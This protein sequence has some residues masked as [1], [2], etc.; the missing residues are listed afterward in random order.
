MSD[1]LDTLEDAKLSEVF[2]VEVA[3]GPRCSKCGHFHDELNNVISEVGFA[4]DANA[5]LPWL[6][7]HANPVCEK[8]DGVWSVYLFTMG[9]TPKASDKSL[10]RAACIALIRA[11]RASK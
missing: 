11:K 9:D 6:E 2:A 8:R 4:T 3:Y 1:E 7:K 10:A 5:V